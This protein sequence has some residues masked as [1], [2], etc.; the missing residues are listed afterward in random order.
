MRCN[1]MA[2]CGTLRRT[3]QTLYNNN[4]GVICYSYVIS[5]RWGRAVF[6]LFKF[7]GVVTGVYCRRDSIFGTLVMHHCYRYLAGCKGLCSF[8]IFL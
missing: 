6:M 5:E 3:G 7:S 1:I 4:T 2:G 8:A